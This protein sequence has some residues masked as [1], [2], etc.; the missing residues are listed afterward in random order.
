MLCSNLIGMRWPNKALQPISLPPLPQVGP[1]ADGDRAPLARFQADTH[2]LSEECDDRYFLVGPI[3]G[4]RWRCALPDA[5][6]YSCTFFTFATLLAILGK[7]A[8]H[9][10]R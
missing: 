3:D 4:R 8:S 1:V 7:G 2:D 6:L 10:I 9:A 5:L